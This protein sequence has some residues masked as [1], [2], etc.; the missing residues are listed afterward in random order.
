MSNQ[1]IEFEPYALRCCGLDIHKAEIVATVEGEGIVKETKFSGR[2][3]RLAARRGKKRA[4]VAL[5]REILIIVYNML[6]NGTEYKELGVD[7]MDDRRKQAQINYYKEQL[8]KLT[9]ED[10][11]ETQSA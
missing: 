2:Y 11:P 10:S 3:K 1:N 4:I 5:G 9:G 8:N 6:K 7:Y